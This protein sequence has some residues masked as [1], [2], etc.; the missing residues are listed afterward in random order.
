MK[1]SRLEESACNTAESSSTCWRLES[2]PVESDP[3]PATQPAPVLY[4][5][6]VDQ[7]E[8]LVDVVGPGVQEGH[9]GI[10]AGEEEFGGDLLGEDCEGEV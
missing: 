8:V 10:E 7:R 4:L 9:D 5:H 6:R 2:Y 3:V 1:S